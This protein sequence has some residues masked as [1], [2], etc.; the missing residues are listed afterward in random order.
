[1][2]DSKTSS[3]IYL[4][5]DTTIDNTPI[6]TIKKSYKSLEL[7]DTKELCVITSNY[8]ENNLFSKNKSK[9]IFF[10]TKVVM[11]NTMLRFVR[12]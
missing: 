11:I 5:L 12:R 1:M 8:L 9:I 4:A 2:M 10:V 7:I 6:K 3:D